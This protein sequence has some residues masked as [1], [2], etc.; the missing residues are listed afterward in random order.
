MKPGGLRGEK[1]IANPA[2]S[3]TLAQ[4]FIESMMINLSRDPTKKD[5]FSWKSWKFQKY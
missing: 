2:E 4:R 3:M 1:N 5:H